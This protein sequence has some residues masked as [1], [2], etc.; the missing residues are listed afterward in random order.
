MYSN[1]TFS[2]ALKRV[3]SSSSPRPRR[4]FIH[5]APTSESKPVR[6]Q[7]T[8]ASKTLDFPLDCDPTTA[9]WGKSIP[10]PPR[11]PADAKMSCKRFTSGTKPLPSVC[12]CICCRPAPPSA[13]AR[14]RWCDMVCVCVCLRRTRVWSFEWASMSTSNRAWINV[15]TCMG[16]QVATFIKIAKWQ[17]W[18]VRRPTT[19]WLQYV[20]VCITN[21]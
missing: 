9:I 5:S 19:S 21:K 2:R 18:N 12:V 10:F 17:H 13:D 15:V 4:A 7:R 16:G 3:S 1:F 11:T 14:T 8:N 20:R 6:R